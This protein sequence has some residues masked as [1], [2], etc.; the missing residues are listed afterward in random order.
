[1]K[2]F[3]SLL[4]A[5]LAGASSLQAAVRTV[6]NSGFP[7]QFPTVAGAVT[8]SANGDTIYI[9]G[10]ALS[11]GNVTLTKSLTFIGEAAW[12]V[13]PAFAATLGTLNLN[14]GSQGS[15]VIGLNFSD[16][17]NVA[18]DNIL[19]ERCR[20]LTASGY[21]IHVTGTAGTRTGLTVQ[22]CHL[23]TLFLNN[24][25]S[26]LIRNNV[27]HNEVLFFGWMLSTSD[28]ATVVITNNLFI[29]NH[30]NTS[31]GS[32]SSVSNAV[33]TNNIF[34][35]ASA[36]P[37]TTTSGCT[38]ASNITW[39]T[40]NNTLPAGNVI[41]PGNL[42]GVDPQFVNAPNRS[43]S[44]TYD[45]A[46]QASSPGVTA[47]SDGTDIGIFGGSLPWPSNNN[48]GYPRLPR[49]TSFTATSTV[50]PVGSSVEVQVEG[51]KVD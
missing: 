50:I 19:V 51:T 6:S 13:S 24:M 12:P 3:A 29:T 10:S 21:N 33:V 31:Y 39:Q 7:A 8:A 22:H 48:T 25:N 5:A 18:S 15:R 32:F 28:K 14:A 27:F 44:V 40:S 34:W 1:M 38:F 20:F 23:R 17:I 35:G 37:G 47:G 43:L 9:Y 41:G 49:V 2:K 16:G 4:I 36:Q 46:L 26:A 11:Y 45:Y 42:Q 30:T